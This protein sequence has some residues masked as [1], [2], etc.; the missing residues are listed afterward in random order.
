MATFAIKYSAV[1]LKHF[2]ARIGQVLEEVDPRKETYIEHIDRP[3]G[4]FVTKAATP[5]CVARHFS[6]Y[7]PLIAR[8]LTLT[9]LVTQSRAGL[10]NGDFESPAERPNISAVSLRSYL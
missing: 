1:F 4:C 5:R 7:Q 2:Q 8:V 9:I 10:R 6:C 3:W